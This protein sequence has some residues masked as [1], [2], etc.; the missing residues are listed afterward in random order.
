MHC[1]NLQ[2]RRDQR[3]IDLRTSFEPAEPRLEHLDFTSAPP[4]GFATHR[5]IIR[6]F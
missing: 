4:L 1:G 5:I 2:C 3:L 6:G